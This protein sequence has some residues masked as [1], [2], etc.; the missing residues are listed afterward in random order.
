MVGLIRSLKSHTAAAVDRFSKHSGILF[1]IRFN[2]KSAEFV[3]ENGANN[4][5]TFQKNIVSSSF[6]GINT[7]IQLVSG[8]PG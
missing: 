2:M 5:G 6:E 7:S 8:T 4:I 1:L 3:I